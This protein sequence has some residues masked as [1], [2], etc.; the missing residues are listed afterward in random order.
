M[1]VAD[2]IDRIDAA[3]AENREV[4][5]QRMQAH[6]MWLL[7]N[8]TQ[9]A[10]VDLRWDES[11]TTVTEYDERVVA[12]VES[13]MWQFNASGLAA[14]LCVRCLT[15]HVYGDFPWCVDTA[16]CEDAHRFLYG[17]NEALRADGVAWNALRGLPQPLQRGYVHVR[18]MVEAL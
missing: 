4:K 8:P 18:P 11:T 13:L 9:M 15:D 12:E 17:T 2:I 16:D 10:L 5:R 14:Y 3:L 1:K 7:D 6:V